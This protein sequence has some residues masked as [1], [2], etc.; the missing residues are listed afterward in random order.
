MR[1]PCIKKDLEHL[2]KEISTFLHGLSSP[3]MNGIFEVKVSID[4]LT[5]LV[6]STSKK[7]LELKRLRIEIL[8]SGT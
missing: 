4:N 6:Y 7:T 2:A 3:I 5:Y 1:K 8:K